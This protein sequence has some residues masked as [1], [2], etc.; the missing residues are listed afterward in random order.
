[1]L[2]Q[3][4]ANLQ[5][6]QLFSGE[7]WKLIFHKGELGLNELFF[8]TQ[9]FDC[10]KLAESCAENHSN[11]STKTQYHN[12]TCDCSPDDKYVIMNLIHV[13]LQY[14]IFMNSEQ[15]FEITC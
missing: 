14:M 10:K 2:A 4:N 11:I 9:I 1:M 7:L 6:I 12:Q 8:A 15:V 13:M 3:L 5:L